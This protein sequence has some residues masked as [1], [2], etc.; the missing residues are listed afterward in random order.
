MKKLELSVL[1]RCVRTFKFL[2]IFWL[3]SPIYDADGL[4]SRP[5]YIK[6]FKLWKGICGGFDCDKQNDFDCAESK[7][8]DSLTSPDGFICA[9]DENGIVTGNTQIPGETD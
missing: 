8:T 9:K 3:T 2:K 5:R 1:L 4:C 7:H 6:F